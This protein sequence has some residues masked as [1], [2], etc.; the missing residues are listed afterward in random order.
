MVYSKD[1]CVY[2]IYHQESHD[3]N[4]LNDQLDSWPVLDGATLCDNWGSLGF[5]TETKYVAG[6][7]LGVDALEIWSLGPGV[8][9]LGKLGLGPE[10]RGRGLCAYVFLISSCSNLRVVV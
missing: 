2:I 6:L 8:G 1:L 7:E 3:H 10:V 5:S 9:G 4:D